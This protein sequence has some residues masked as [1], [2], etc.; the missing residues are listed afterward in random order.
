MCLSQQ[1]RNCC[2]HTRT[3]VAA[4]EMKSRRVIGLH[5]T[6]V[7]NPRSGSLL[8]PSPHSHLGVASPSQSQ[9]VLRP[10]KPP[11]SAATLERGEPTFCSKF[12]ARDSRRKLLRPP[13]V[14]FCSQKMDVP[15]RFISGP[16]HI[17]PLAHRL[18]VRVVRVVVRRRRDVS[19]F[20]AVEHGTD[21]AIRAQ[22]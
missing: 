16:A 21:H 18:R 4:I 6:E 17:V 13:R 1:S 10:R 3:S 7:A 9:C 2:A 20:D 8:N 12:L 11:G 15:A 14:C 5:E 19:P 22:F